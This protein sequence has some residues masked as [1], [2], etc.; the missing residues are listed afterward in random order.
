[1]TNVT[2]PSSV[3]KLNVLI[4]ED[5]TLVGMGL[6]NDLERLGHS[7]IAQAANP[8]E[9]RREYQNRQGGLV[10]MGIRLGSGDGIELAAELLKVRRCR[11]IILSAYGGQKLIE[12]AGVAGVFG[13]LSK[14]VSTGRLKA[15]IEVAVRRFH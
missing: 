5:E 7:V 13:Y 2:P 9:A 6:K 14:P 3:G 10:C 4:V 12:R 15:Q 11:M 1:M 8:D